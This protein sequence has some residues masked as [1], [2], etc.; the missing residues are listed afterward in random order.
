M[1][2][3]LLNFCHEIGT[4]M[5]IISL[6]VLLFVTAGC[7]NLPEVGAKRV[8]YQ[9]SY[10][11]GGTTIDMTAVEV[12]DTH[13]KAETYSRH[14]RWWYFSQDVEIDGYSRQRNAAK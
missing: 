9:S 12:T 11:I 13:V 4:A 2:K 3:F 6:L 7:A 1:T 14:S 10:P 5:I 8:H